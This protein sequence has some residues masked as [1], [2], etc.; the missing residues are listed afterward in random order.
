MAGDA[1]KHWRK[2]FKDFIGALG[3]WP[4][5]VLLVLIVL[6]S[7]VLK[8]IFSRTRLPATSDLS[9]ETLLGPDDEPGLLSAG[10]VPVYGYASASSV[11]QGGTLDFHI[12]A[13]VAS[14]NIKIYRYGVNGLE[15]KMTVTNLPPGAVHGC[16]PVGVPAGQEHVN[17]GCDWPVAYTLQVPTN[18][19]SGVYLATVWD[20]DGWPGG[21]GSHIFFIVKED[22]PASNAKILFQLPTN[23]WQAYNDYGGWSLYTNPPGRR[24]T[25]DRPYQPCYTGGGCVYKWEIPLV[26]WLESEGYAV[27]YIASEDLHADPSLLFNYRLF[28]TAGHDEYWSKEIRDNLDAFV[29]AGGNAAIFS[30]NT[31]YR[32]IRYE[33]SG[34]TLVC[35]KWEDRTRDPLYGVDNIRVASEFAWDPAFWPE[36]STTGLGWREGGWVNATPGNQ[37]AGRYTVYRSDHW[38]YEGTGLHDGSVFWYEP[39]ATVE[40]DGAE[41]T[42]EHGLPVVTGSDDTPADFTILGLQPATKLEGEPRGYATMGIFSRDGGGTIFNAATMGWP[43]GLWPD[44]NPNHYQIVRRITRNVIDRLSSGPPSPPAYPVT[45]TSFTYQPLTP[46]PNETVTFIAAITPSSAT[47]PITFTWN[48]GDGTPGTS[49]TSNTI[50]HAFGVAA[51]YTVGVTASNNYGQSTFSRA[52]EVIPLSSPNPDAHR[53]YL[54]FVTR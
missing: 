40:V 22:Q 42:W 19:P 48:F 30:G 10:A 51:T 44:T 11:P 2:P 21:Y 54:P 28:I 23:T 39:S 5:I 50:S 26:R 20:Q 15:L 34:R 9:N 18:W 31:S 1:G 35:Y 16:G 6:G 12:S 24:I 46:R 49:T 8:D 13:S 27:D 32:Q 29:A 45:A 14:Y 25:F 38:V 7:I 47:P 41:F 37:A 53:V 4:L 17:L 36:N 52:V 43:R 33:E 3:K